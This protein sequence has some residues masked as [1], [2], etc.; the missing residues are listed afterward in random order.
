MSNQ[1]ASSNKAETT[2]LL[3]QGV[4]ASN[5]QQQ[6][7]AGAQYNGKQ[8][9]RIRI[10]G[11]GS[12]GI[13]SVHRR[14][15][16]CS[17]VVL[18]EIDLQRFKGEQERQSAINEARIMSKL[19]HVNIIKYYNAY[20]TSSKLIIEMEYASIGTLGAYLSFQG[21]ALEEHEIL[22]IFRQ[23]VSG[24]NYLHS[25]NIMHLDLKMAN[26]F[27]TIEG[28]VKIGDFGI[29]Q[30]LHHSGPSGATQGFGAA[31]KQLN[32][33]SSSSK[34]LTSSHL[35]TLS[36]SSPE[37]CLGEHTDL[38]SDIW[39]LGCILYELI[40]SKPMF[41][42]DSLLELVLNI[43]RVQ[44]QPIRRANLTA[45]LIETFE[46][47]VS[48]DP[49]DRPSA[50][51]L[52]CIANQLVLQTQMQRAHQ[53]QSRQVL[54]K[55]QAGHAGG[56]GGAFDLTTEL[57]LIKQANA[58]QEDVSQINYPH[59]LVYQVR[60]DSRNIHMDRVNLPQTKRIKGMSK[61]DSHYLVL[62]YDNI[63]YG[64]GSKNYGQLGACGLTSSNT[65]NKSSTANS[66]RTAISASRSDLMSASNSANSSPASSTQTIAIS[67]TTSS[68]NNHSIRSSTNN[69]QQQQ[70]HLSKQLVMSMLEQSQPSSRP[71][72]INELNHRKII[73][74][75]AGRNF[76]VFLSKTGIV[77]TCGDGSTGCLGRGDL[78][79]CFTPCMVESLLNTDVVSIACGPKHVVA[80]CGNGRA[81]AWGKL[82]FG[83]L[84]IGHPSAA[85]VGSTGGSDESFK[86]FLHDN[87]LVLRPQPVQIPPDV[88]IKSVFCADRSTVFIDSQNRCWACG[89]NRFNKLGLDLKRRLKKNLFVDKCW[90]P[91]EITALSKYKIIMCNMGK[92][93]S[94]FITSEGK[95]IVFG[96]DIDHTYRLKSNIVGARDSHRK[97][98]LELQTKRCLSNHLNPRSNRHRSQANLSRNSPV[99]PV[100]KAN[101]PSSTNY[102]LLTQSTI[103]NNQLRSFK[104][105][106]QSGTTDETIKRKKYPLYKLNKFQRAQIDSYVSKSRSIKKMPFECVVKVSCT[107][108]FTLALTSDNRVYFWGTRSYKKEGATA[109]CAAPEIVRSHNGFAYR[110][111]GKPVKSSNEPQ[112]VAGC[113]DQCFIKI[114]ATNSSLMSNIQLLGSDHPIIHAQDPRLVAKSLADLWILDYRP[115][116]SCSSSSSSSSNSSSSLNLHQIGPKQNSLNCSASSLSSESS[117][118]SLCCARTTS[119][120]LCRN[121]EDSG[122]LEKAT[123][124]ITDEDDDLDDC[125][126]HAAILEPQPIVSLYV[127]SMFNNLNN[128]CSLHLVDLFCFDEDRFY[129]ILDTTIR[130]Q[131]YN[132]RQASTAASGTAATTGQPSP[133]TNQSKMLPA[134]LRLAPANL[135]PGAS[136]I[137]GCKGQPSAGKQAAV[138]TA[139]NDKIDCNNI[140]EAPLAATTSKALL[141]SASDEEQ[142]EKRTHLE[143]SAQVMKTSQAEIYACDKFDLSNNNKALSPEVDMGV[144]GEKLTEPLDEKK[145][146]CC[147]N[148]NNNTTT[149]SNDVNIDNTAVSSSQGGVSLEEPR[150]LSTFAATSLGNH[151]VVGP[152]M[153]S[154]DIHQQ[155]LRALAF[156]QQRSQVSGDSP[157]VCCGSPEAGTGSESCES[158]I[159][160][161]QPNHRHRRRRQTTNRSES[162]TAYTCN[163]IEETSSMPSWVRNEYQHQQKNGFQPNIFAVDSS[164]TEETCMSEL[165]VTASSMADDESMDLDSST[166]M[167]SFKQNLNGGAV[168][169]A[170]QVSTPTFSGH[171]ARLNP[172]SSSSSIESSMDSKLDCCNSASFNSQLISQTIPAQVA[173]DGECE[174]LTDCKPLVG[175]RGSKNSNNHIILDD[176]KPGELEQA[177][178]SVPQEVG[179]SFPIASPALNGQN[180]TGLSR[181]QP[182]ITESDARTDPRRASIIIGAGNEAG[183]NLLHCAVYRSSS[184]HNG[185][186]NYQSSSNFNSSISIRSNSHNLLIRT[187]PSS[188][189]DLSAGSHQRISNGTSSPVSLAIG[190][191]AA[192]NAV[193]AAYFWSKLHSS[194]NNNNNSVASNNANHEQLGIRGTDEQPPTYKY[195]KQ[196]IL[197][198][199]RQLSQSNQQLSIKGSK[200]NG[201][202]SSLA[203]L[204]KSFVKLFC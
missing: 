77:M 59:S 100:I 168:I 179:A 197:L 7:A 22:I 131:H 18:K 52:L 30:Y 151:I 97:I 141:S 55:R 154:L 156:G 199:G 4:A 43:T 88:F 79:S 91:R 38:K 166:T 172:S 132:A 24:L 50:K 170:G 196:R 160:H 76:S 136:P 123:P 116:Q 178:D 161:A 127:P 90:L 152:T 47:T 109:L 15:A 48:R 27:V 67:P 129:L 66:S 11:K 103:Y 53:Q 85:D 105:R 110:K 92:N 195:H 28:L 192:N 193:E 144:D 119:C 122:D 99:R 46:Q 61:G 31:N 155:P 96:Q 74:V 58:S 83:R 81:F 180:R 145:L 191:Q 202:S 65:G 34:K 101:L 121:H 41:S 112:L 124:I 175:S 39:S 140:K 150:S 111:N 148:N 1:Q 86:S 56:G 3:A 135:S 133:D 147:D 84:G 194:N 87:K 134:K 70:Q 20:T 157:D 32:N 118:C 9:D 204:R 128:N 82:E 16:D 73:Q 60:L 142:T 93:H 89:E 117:S 21:Q 203:S 14:R 163:D 130:L 171:Q 169:S 94:S 137:S 153:R 126:K 120:P 187:E 183:D 54:G 143:E 107:S 98:A 182:D 189:F 5:P 63:V 200:R 44:Y 198:A 69:Q 176:Y 37:R 2:Q 29:A 49:K 40:S 36:Y 62:T 17:L 104:Y 19:S 108:K 185:T 174:T 164:A 78:K 114:G 72:I 159:N 184:Q 115:S 10:L 190:R 25:M 23:I 8:Y 139:S 12:F 6:V 102:K 186:H 80:V 162:T 51:E 106:N 138:K 45:G 13:A 158:S 167:A 71:F 173:G 165:S 113:S 35:G 181:S 42:G 57:A 33:K 75:A 146:N 149:N 177:P 188:R 68:T 125:M 64:W 201:S 26:I 95:L